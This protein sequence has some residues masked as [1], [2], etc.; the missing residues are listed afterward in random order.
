MAL[1]ALASAAGLLGS[2]IVIAAYLA[3]QQEWLRARDW[4]YSALNL[5]GALLIL[6]SLFFA[7]N[8]PSVVI[9][10]FWAAISLHGL[11]RALRLDVGPRRA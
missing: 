1:P 4:R 7:W 11:W 2:A 9:E 5:I 3:N 10:A 8:W 6:A